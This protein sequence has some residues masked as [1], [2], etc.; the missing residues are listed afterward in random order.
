VIQNLAQF[1]CKCTESGINGNFYTC[2]FVVF[3]TSSAL[4]SFSHPFV[5]IEDYSLGSSPLCTSCALS[6]TQLGSP[7]SCHWLLL[8]VLLVHCQ[9]TICVHESLLLFCSGL[10]VTLALLSYFK[11]CLEA[12]MNPSW[13]D[14]VCS[15]YTWWLTL[16]FYSDHIVRLVDARITQY[17]CQP[18]S[19]T[20][21]IWQS[22]LLLI[23]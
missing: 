16:L 7:S 17:D 12:W 13:M 4:T 8:S 10:R 11:V 15:H 20:C 21:S 18:W 23:I 2:D 3:G 22:L 5:A 14:N 9:N 19:F 1:K 6:L